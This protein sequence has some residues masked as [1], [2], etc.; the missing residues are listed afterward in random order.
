MDYKIAMATQLSSLLKNTRKQLGFT[1][2]EMGEKLGVSQVMVAKIEAN[3]Q[4]ARFERILQML[5]IL[6]MDL[7]VRERK[8]KPAQNHVPGDD[9][10]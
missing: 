2:K 5:S 1:Q 6:Q 4:G 10:W 7:I 9:S 8:S 3:P